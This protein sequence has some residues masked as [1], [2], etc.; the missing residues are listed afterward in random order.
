MGVTPL[1]WKALENFT[2][3]YNRAIWTCPLKWD[4]TNKRVIYN[5]LSAS[6]IPWAVA[7][8]GFTILILLVS[9]CL[10]LL[11]IF[12]IV[13]L[14]LIH[15][16]VAT[17]CTLVLIFGGIGEIVCLYGENLAYAVNSAV[18]FYTSMSK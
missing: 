4:P 6:L 8:F 7:V 2:K 15:G 17:F 13:D 9:L 5:K 14:T 1:M 12:G 11:H 16:I 18:Y 10:L 3:F